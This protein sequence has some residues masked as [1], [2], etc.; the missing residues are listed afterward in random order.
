MWKLAGLRKDSSNHEL[1]L[2]LNPS[3]SAFHF[4]DYL[5]ACAKVSVSHLLAKE[6][7][8]PAAAGGSKSCTKWYV[9]LATEENWQQR[10][11]YPVSSWRYEGN[12]SIKFLIRLPVETWD[13]FFFC[14]LIVWQGIRWQFWLVFRKAPSRADV[15]M[16][17]VLKNLTSCSVKQVLYVKVSLFFTRTYS[18]ESHQA[19]SRLWLHFRLD[20]ESSEK[21]ILI[22][23]IFEHFLWVSDVWFT[24]LLC[25]NAL[26]ILFKAALLTFL[27]QRQINWL[28]A[29]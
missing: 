1:L 22:K 2:I 23:A 6:V 18:A 19:V 24:D 20:L 10:V 25:R 9:C 7:W 26:H 11:I 12:G 28:W 4:P 27:H 15:S 13:F 29:V 5:P 3:R 17:A 8:Y 14:W 16:C 21:K